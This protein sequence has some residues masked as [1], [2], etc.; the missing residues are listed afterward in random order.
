MASTLIAASALPLKDE[1]RDAALVILDCRFQLNDKRAGRRA[2]DAGHVPGAHYAD[3]EADL[4][5][6][7]V[8]GV[9]GRHPL[10]ELSEL[11]QKLRAW[12]VTSAAR[13]IAYDDAGGAM[14][15]RLWWLLRW[16]GHD[17]VF[18]CDGGYQAWLAAGGEPTRA[19]PPPAAGD[20]EPRP[21]S[22]WVVSTAEVAQ[23]APSTVLLDA[24]AH[25]RYRGE[26]EPIDA[27]PGHIP[28]ALCVPVA[29][30]LT[31]SGAFADPAALAARYRAV[32]RGAAPENVVVYCGSGVTACHDILAA[33][34]AGLGVFRLYA[35]SYSEWIADASRPVT[36]GDA[37]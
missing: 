12:G 28:G 22:G 26:V 31:A 10:P 13:V 2:Y 23:R 24:R 37:P 33:E 30:N 8:P 5:G 34:H 35:G 4:S 14:A 3:L 9:T 7:I 27:V 21:R 18:V 20:F 25:E 15:A 16:L 29:G 6:P 17:A 36:T 1:P 32:V 11:A 19:S